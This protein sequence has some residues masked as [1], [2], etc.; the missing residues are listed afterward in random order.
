MEAMGTHV[1]KSLKPLIMKEA[2]HKI[3]QVKDQVAETALHRLNRQDR[4]LLER[5]RR[6][7]GPA[8]RKVED[9]SIRHRQE[10]WPE[11]WL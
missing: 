4:E 10:E 7:C 5:E 11:V 9:A 8:N 6:R 3:C 1:V 2:H